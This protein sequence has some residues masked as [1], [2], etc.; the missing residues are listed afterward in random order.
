M[1]V[2]T[3]EAFREALD[4]L[5]AQARLAG[6]ASVDVR[7]GDLHRAVGVY[8]PPGHRMPMCCAAMRAAMHPNDKIT[9][10]PP[11]GDG[12]SVVVRYKLK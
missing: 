5:L 11:N 9:A 2:L 8:P 1:V 6:R 7:A 4:S 12:P 3:R 10:Q